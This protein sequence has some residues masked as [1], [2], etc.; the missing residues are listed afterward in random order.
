MEPRRGVIVPELERWSRDAAESEQR[1]AI[2][3]LRG[4]TDVDR[5]VG[6]LTEIGMVIASS[7]P[8]SVIGRVSP[9]ALRR[10]GQETWVLAV[11]VP[12]TLR[13]FPHD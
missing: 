12:Q 10:I 11:D 3:R 5:A 9:P 6:R 8:G 1:T 13:S 7:G 4:G 2:V